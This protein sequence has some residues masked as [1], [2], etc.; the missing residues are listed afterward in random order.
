M[1]GV[2]NRVVSMKFDNAAFETGAATTMST[3]DKLRQALS[4]TG[5]TKGMTDVQDAAKKLDLSPVSAAVE[6]VSARFLAMSA[7]A[8]TV[9]SNITNRAVD[10]GIQMG[11]SLTLDQVKDG[12]SEYETKIGAIQ[13]ILANTQKFGTTL[14]QV[15]DAL[16]ELN[17]YADKTIYSFGEMTKTVGLFTNAGIKVEDATAM[18]KG[19]SN[20]AAA[21]GANAEN[22]ARAQYSCH[23]LCRPVQFASWTGNPSP[24][25]AWATPT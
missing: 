10:A 11:K 15:T 13:T 18:I 12:F 5:G 2:D 20:A 16:N 21:S 14:P 4:L 25:L 24:T 17:N 23:R 1:S 19:F 6:N 22:T 8:I 7:V 3:L 9:L